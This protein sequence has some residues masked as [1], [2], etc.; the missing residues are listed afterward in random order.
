MYPRPL[1]NTT[2]LTSA[3]E[4]PA[5]TTAHKRALGSLT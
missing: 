3:A 5:D 4:L 1:A 2:P